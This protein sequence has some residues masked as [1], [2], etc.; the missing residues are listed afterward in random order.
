M[1]ARRAPSLRRRLVVQLLALAAVLAVLLFAAVRF[2]AER[3]SEA[4]LDAILGAATIAMAEEIRSAEGG[5]VIDLSPG[6]F[7]MLA[8]MGDERIFY[9]VNQIGRAH[10]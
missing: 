4:T 3:A 8:A 5:A 2:S 6:T 7:S 1:T 9:R 10:V